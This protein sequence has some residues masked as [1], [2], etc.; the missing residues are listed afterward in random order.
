MTSNIPGVTHG[1]SQ[2]LWLRKATA[3]V[4]MAMLPGMGYMLAI[5]CIPE[6]YL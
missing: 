3:V 2:D 4:P 5:Y 6:Y 1:H